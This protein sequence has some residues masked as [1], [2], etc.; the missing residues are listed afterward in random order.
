[1]L[2][3]ITEYSTSVFILRYRET[4]ESL[5][6]SIEENTKKINQLIKVLNLIEN[7]GVC[8]QALKRNSLNVE[9]QAYQP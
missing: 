8:I 5:K 4:I 2:I 7:D 1:M 3:T 9:R 6:L